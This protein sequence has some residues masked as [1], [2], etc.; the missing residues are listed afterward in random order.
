[1]LVIQ[2]QVDSREEEKTMPSTMVHHFSGF[3][4]IKWKI[5][6]QANVEFDLFSFFYPSLSLYLTLSVSVSCTLN[7]IK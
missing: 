7:S 2:F 1:M 4:A 5:D 6:V 3:H